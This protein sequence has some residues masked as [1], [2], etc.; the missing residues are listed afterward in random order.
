MKK[1]YKY[2]AFLIVFTH[3][4]L[5]K[6]FAGINLN[7]S[8]SMMNGW[9]P[10][11][12]RP[13]LPS[14]IQISSQIG[15]IIKFFILPFLISYFMYSSIVSPYR[16]YKFYKWKTQEEKKNIFLALTIHNYILR[17]IIIIVFLILSLSLLFT[18]VYEEYFKSIIAIISNISYYYI[19]INI[20]VWLYQILKKKNKIVW[21][22]I[23]LKSIFFFIVIFLSLSIY[24]YIIL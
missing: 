11:P 6:S 20:W 19:S 8:T 17:W 1:I 21:Q 13:S 12:I 10:G 5:N 22:N 24:N 4:L 2:L 9:I 16:F 18:D 14:A 15:I 23:I 7:G 3:E